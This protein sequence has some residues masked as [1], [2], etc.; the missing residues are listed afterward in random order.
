MVENITRAQ[1]IIFDHEYRRLHQPQVID[2]WYFDPAA[3]CSR[4][5]PFL[6]QLRFHFPP[7][8]QHYQSITEDV[9]TLPAMRAPRLRELGLVNYFVLFN[10]AFIVSLD[11]RRCCFPS[12][13]FRQPLP[14]PSQF[15]Q[16]MLSCSRLPKLTL[17]NWISDLTPV[18]DPI[19]ILPHLTMVDIL[20]SDHSRSLNPLAFLS[21]MKV[22]PA[23]SYRLG[24]GDLDLESHNAGQCLKSLDHHIR[25]SALESYIRSSTCICSFIVP[26]SDFH[27]HLPHSPRM[28]TQKIF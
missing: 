24:M 7:D 9:F 13:P 16:I 20:D 21:H 27:S 4:D 3:M 22:P 26:P 8:S 10:G 25:C 28:V 15:I 17:H 23:A 5:L 6:Q 19:I 18:F 12:Q 11:L 1:V 14:S 2:M